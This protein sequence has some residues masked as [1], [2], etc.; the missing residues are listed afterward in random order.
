MWLVIGHDRTFVAMIDHLSGACEKEIE[1][2]NAQGVSMQCW[3]SF[4]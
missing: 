4:A 2:L 1:T 3:Q